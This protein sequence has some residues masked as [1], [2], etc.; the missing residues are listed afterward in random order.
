MRFKLIERK[1]RFGVFSIKSTGLS[2]KALK[3]L[4]FHRC[5]RTSVYIQIRAVQ[6]FLH[7]SIFN[8]RG[9]YIEMVDRNR[10]EK[11]WIKDRKNS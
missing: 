8:K 2:A 4:L 10:A 3:V 7:F 5:R 1:D 6:G 9:R 11:S